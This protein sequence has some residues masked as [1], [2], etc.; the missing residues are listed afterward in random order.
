M[1]AEA[2]FAYRKGR[3]W[4]DALRK[5]E[6]CRDQGLRWVYRADIEAFFDRISHE[7]LAVALADCLAEPAAAS[8]ALA[9]ASAPVVTDNGVEAR[10]VGVPQG[11]PVSPVLANVVLAG[12]DRVV[13]GRWGRLVRYADDMAVF[14]GDAHSVRM[15]AFETE[16]SS[17]SRAAR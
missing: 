9:W 12:F 13:D 2:S 8:L 11:A 14:C 5:A 17:G 10:S 15:A 1:M 6:R 16:G 7:Q 3:S 4:L